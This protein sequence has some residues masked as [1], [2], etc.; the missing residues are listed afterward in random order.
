MFESA[1]NELAQKA[2]EN[3][4]QFLQTLQQLKQLSENKD[5]T[6]ETLRSVQKGLMLAI[7]SS[8]FYPTK[9]N[10]FSD[11]INQLLLKELEIHD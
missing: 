2:I 3:P 6:S 4:G 9:S 10:R 11:Q 8:E 1:G 7:P 5:A